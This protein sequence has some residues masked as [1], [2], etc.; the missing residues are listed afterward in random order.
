MTVMRPDD[1]VEKP[2]FLPSNPTDPI[3][4]D[5][6]AKAARTSRIKESIHTVARQR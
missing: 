5:R 3:I 2:C 6:P 1:A 4:F